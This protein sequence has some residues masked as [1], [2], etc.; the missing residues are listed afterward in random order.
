MAVEILYNSIH[1]LTHPDAGVLRLV[2]YGH[3][4]EGQ[5]KITR[6][7][8]EAVVTKL[9]SSGLH[10]VNGLSEAKKLLTDAGYTVLAPVAENESL[11][12]TRTTESLGGPGEPDAIAAAQA[13]I[14]EVIGGAK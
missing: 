4:S 2:Y 1:Q 5:K 6:Q 10:I 9:E 14:A 11:L 12:I 7:V 3:Q 8:S 13:K